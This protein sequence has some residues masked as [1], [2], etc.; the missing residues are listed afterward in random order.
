MNANAPST[1]PLESKRI[2]QF[3]LHIAKGIPKF[4]NN[5]ETLDIL[6]AKS[7]GSLLIDYINWASRLIPPRPLTV[8]IEPTLTADT[9]WKALSA[10][11]KTFLERVKRGDNLNPNLSLRAF[12]N[13]F[14]PA[15]SST[16]P[17][18]DK[19]EDKDFILNTMGDHHFHLS[20]IVEA[21]GHTTRTNEVLFAQVTKDKFF[22][23]GIFDHSVFEPTDQTTKTMSVE[24]ERLWRVFD[25]RNSRGREQGGFY[26]SSLITTSGHSMHHT[27]LATEFARVIHAIDQKL[28]N[29]SS[30]SEVF[31][32]LPHEV[33]KA[34][35]LRWHLDYLNLGVIDRITS[36]FHV[37]RYGLP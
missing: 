6:E 16:D 33:V 13:G 15:S 32:D 37:F 9:R 22:A 1:I 14:T 12:H 23:I 28:D 21:A 34:M 25:Q 2:K 36:T 24:K 31:K 26:I 4:P 19:W 7:I 5:K 29:L 10:D 27:T 11:I 20:Q 8:I 18:T 30:R 17:S 35:K 3:R